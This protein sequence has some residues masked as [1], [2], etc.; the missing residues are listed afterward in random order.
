M[1]TTTAT[2]RSFNAAILA[3]LSTESDRWPQ[4]VIYA[5]ES[6]ADMIFGACNA[7]ATPAD[8][9]VWLNV[10]GDS[11]GELTGDH[12]ADAD[13]IECNMFDD[14]VNDVNDAFLA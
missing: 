5:E 13:G 11:F 10:E 2:R 9:I 6:G 8:A 14:A 1:K 4:P 7:P 12:Q 3:V